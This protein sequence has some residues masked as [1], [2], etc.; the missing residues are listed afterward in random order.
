MHRHYI[1]VLLALL[2][3]AFLSGAA[4]G[5]TPAGATLPTSAFPFIENQG[6]FAPA[7]RFQTQHGPHT[8]WL[9]AD[10][11]WLTLTNPAGTQATSLKF[12][13]AA[14]I[15]SP[16]GLQP[17]TT[18]ISYLGGQG[19]PA[20]PV[21]GAVR[22]GAGA[23]ALTIRNPAGLLTLSAPAGALHLALTGA[24]IRAVAHNQLLLD[25]A[26]GPAAIPLP[27]ASTPW[28][29]HGHDAA[30]RAIT[31]TLPAQ[32]APPTPAGISAE[33][34]SYSTYLGGSLLDRGNAVA[35]DPQGNAYVTGHTQSL[36]FPETE[37]GVT[38]L[39]GVDVYVAKIN[40]GGGSVGY[41]TWINP[42]PDQPD[43]EDYGQDIAVDS[44]GH[45][46][47]TGSTKTPVFCEFLG[48]PPG[49]DTTYNGNTDAILLKFSPQGSSLD[50]CNYLGGS[51][52]DSANSLALDSQ[53]NVYVGGGTWSDDF[54]V[55]PGA[56]SGHLTAQRD[57]FITKVDPAGLNILYSTY[58]GG[59]GQEEIT[60][61]AL[62]GD[63]NIF[64]TGW[65][66]S[67]D[68]PTTASA[69]Q[70]TYQGAFDAFALK[71]NPAGSALV[72]NSYL[73]GSAEDRGWGV[74]VD[75]AGRIHVAGQTLSAADFPTSSNGFDTSHNGDQDGFV[76]ILNGAGSNLRYGTFL[77]GAGIDI[78]RD[79]T[80]GDSDQ[81]YLAG[82]TQSAAFPV[83]PNA[84]S[85][86]LNGEVD[87]FLVQ[88][89]N[90]GLLAYGTFLGG[91]NWDYGSG[92]ALDGEN[93][94]YLTGRTLSA[95]FPTT[96]GS[97]DPTH[98]GDYDIFITRFTAGD[99][100][101]GSSTYLP[102]LR[103]P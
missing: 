43:D 32:T 64:A 99:V 75:P 60:S 24:T 57:T 67:A 91:S 8:A 97:A 70:P 63:N 39:H 21:W 22:Y 16:A 48:T 54:P 11:L 3:A 53:G 77:G 68:F 18:V 59:S 41:A 20:V 31:L 89:D 40:A 95:D 14:P 10:A 103:R 47:V 9:T 73:G 98:N 83:T 13:L 37:G 88:I 94:I 46:Y 52:F 50:Y 45:A 49:F 4:L 100:T 5:D 33:E 61:L 81:I 78:V 85:G 29:L 2:L 44:G 66:N 55:T 51:D 15:A 42:N 102:L 58:V 34:L 72:Y 80:L 12:S 69:F 25:T 56:Y 84:F 90:F 101:A 17:Q 71:L 36:D 7:V 93:N 27:L 86:S 65:T 62:D 82:E 92:V 26:I 96:A 79:V 87:A 38:E 28:Q 23:G 30:G 19:Y 76:V 35:V 1:V 6:Q 74:A